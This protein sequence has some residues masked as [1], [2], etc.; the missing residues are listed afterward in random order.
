MLSGQRAFR[1][2]DA[3]QTMNAILTEEPRELAEAN[4]NVPPALER[5]VARCLGKNPDERFQS[6]KDL[7]FALETLMNAPSSRLERMA[8][9]R[10]PSRVSRGWKWA[11]GAG[12]ALALVWFGVF[13][14][15]LHP[16]SRPLTAIW[17]EISPPHP[18]F[19]AR[20]APA[21]SPDGRQIAFWSADQAGKVGLWVR[22]LDS[23]VARLLPGTTSDGP[24][25][26]FAAF[27]S[28]DGQSLGFFAERR[29]KRIDA[30]A[31]TPL[32]LAD[33]GNP[34]G[35]TW[36]TSGV[37]VFVPVTGGPVCRISASGGE[38]TSLP[39][40]SE[41]NASGFRWPHFLPDGKHFLVNDRVDGVFLAAL[42][43]S[44]ARKM[45]T[46]DSRV[47]YADGHLFFGRNGNLFAQRFDER[48][49]KLS[50][51]P[52][53]VAENL[54]LSGGDVSDYAFSVS[55]RGTI[56]YCDSQLH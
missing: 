9:V 36:S 39:V 37:I 52:F 14:G 2:D 28:P 43:E 44:D 55:P 20:P 48:Q 41:Q 42:D 29:L 23:P 16:S 45:S 24:A 1:K 49:L 30:S 47:E 35:G 54:G 51:E 33:A 25:G 53:R 21:I 6:A 15:R 27:W 19:A 50:G 3:V 13:A 10:Q 46:I 22:S 34:R 4:P 17:V 31:G 26:G 56:V 40:R 5:I 38:V 18:R 12:C 8:A 7:A 32:I 11:F